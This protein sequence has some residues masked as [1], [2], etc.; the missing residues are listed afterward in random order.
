MYLTL[1]QGTLQRSL[2]SLATR[3]AN[4]EKAAV[5]EAALREGGVGSDD[6][7]MHV[8]FDSSTNTLRR[9][10][11]LLDR[12]RRTEHGRCGVGWSPRGRR[13]RTGTDTPPAPETWG[14]SSQWAATLPG[15][16]VWGSEP[17]RS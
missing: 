2:G 6:Y 13:R 16:M 17:R 9:S 12:S 15:K 8:D 7:V 4:P 14:A 3:F 5:E 1:R 11:T 10:K